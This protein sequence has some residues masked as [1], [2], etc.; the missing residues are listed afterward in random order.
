M[1]GNANEID[2]QNGEVHE[3][4]APLLV[5]LGL[6]LSLAGL[7]QP[8]FAIIGLPLLIYG[9]WNWVSEDVALWKYRPDTTEEPGDASWAMIWI[10]VTEVIVFSAFFAYWFW[11]R[12]HTISWEDAVGGSWP[13][14]GVV[15]D[16]TLVSINTVI[17]VTSGFTAHKALDSVK[18]GNY[19]NSK[20]MLRITV[21]LGAI[22]LAI[23]AYEYIH[24]GFTWKDHA[25]G[26]AFFALTGLHGLHVLVGALS[27]FVICQLI[28]KGHIHKNHWDSFRAVV[29]YW[30]FV[31]VVWVLLYFIVYLE[32]I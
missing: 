1:T 19:A 22:F 12:W 14:A 20:L 5:S 25:Y 17:L 26:T 31:D 21:L 23:Q 16:M 15:H 7:L 27:L 2:S 28:G 6:T 32:V 10:I 11:A 18:E 24:A 30:H 8:L 3:S 13:A 29:W 4:L 9:I